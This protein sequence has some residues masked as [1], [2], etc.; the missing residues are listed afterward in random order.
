MFVVQPLLIGNDAQLEAL[1]G[2]VRLV[3]SPIG[4]HVLVVASSASTAEHQWKEEAS[5]QYDEGTEENQDWKEETENE[6]QSQEEPESKEYYENGDY[7]DR[8]KS[9]ENDYYSEKSYEESTTENQELEESNDYTE[10]N[11]AESENYG[12]AEEYESKPDYGSG[13]NED[14]EENSTEDSYDKNEE[15]TNESESREGKSAGGEGNVENSESGNY[16]EKSLNYQKENGENQN[17]V[18]DT[19][20]KRQTVEVISD[21]K[22]VQSAD[23]D[24]IASV[25]ETRKKDDKS[26]NPTKIYQAKPIHVLEDIVVGSINKSKLEDSQ[27]QD[28][29]NT[30]GSQDESDAKDSSAVLTLSPPPKETEEVQLSPVVYHVSPKLLQIAPVQVMGL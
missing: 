10:E 22:I 13:E 25:N 16:Y 18:P 24:G 11:E 17:S 20:S 12:K 23:H 30:K 6:E 14:G 27:N 7:S 3:L 8:K 2:D 9:E 1:R 19:E 5:E 29:T 21:Q 15:P 26:I 4:G 28:A